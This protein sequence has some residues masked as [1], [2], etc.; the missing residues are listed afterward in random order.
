MEASLGKISILE[1]LLTRATEGKVMTLPWN[2]ISVGFGPLV[3]HQHSEDT[4]RQFRER[5]MMKLHRGYGVIFEM[6]GDRIVKVIC[7]ALENEEDRE[8]LSLHL[9]ELRAMDQELNRAKMR[10]P[11]WS[12][13]F[14]HYEVEALVEQQMKLRERLGIILELVEGLDGFTQVVGEDEMIAEGVLWDGPVVEALEELKMVEQ[15]LKAK[16]WGH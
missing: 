11:K 2:E 8:M 1:Q 10:E 5:F 3:E 13:L 6:V 16:R 4:L 9:E 15:T 7:P 12:Q 14:S